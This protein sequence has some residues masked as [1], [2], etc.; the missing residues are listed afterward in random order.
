MGWLSK[1]FK[2]S[3]LKDSE[4]HSHTNYGGDANRYAPTSS[5]VITSTTSSFHFIPI[6]ANMYDWNG[7][8]SSYYS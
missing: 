2:L 1:I 8:A 4:E 5:G 3:G 6:S 7:H